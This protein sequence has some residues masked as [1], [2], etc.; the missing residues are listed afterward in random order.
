MLELSGCEEDA[1]RL[2]DEVKTQNVRNG[3]LK[4]KDWICLDASVWLA[5]CIRELDSQTELGD[6]VVKHPWVK[7]HALRV[8]KYE[9]AIFIV[10]LNSMHI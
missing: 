9:L 10:Q 4:D 8:Y 1:Y 6:Q 3:K 7:E 2:L 5:T